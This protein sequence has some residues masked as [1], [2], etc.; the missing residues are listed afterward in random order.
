ML[1]AEGRSLPPI[2]GDRSVFQ[3]DFTGDDDPIH[4]FNWSHRRR[5]VLLF[6]C[7]MTTCSSTFSSAIFSQAIQ[8]VSLEYHVAPIVATLGVSLF[9]FGFST[10]PL[11]WGPMSEVFGRKIV[12]SMT[13]LLCAIFL[14]S[15]AASRSIQAIL[16]TRFFG[17]FFGGAPQA[18]VGGVMADIYRPQHR[19]IALGYFGFATFIGPLMAPIVGSY[20]VKNPHLNW[21]LLQIVAGAFQVLV[22][23]LLLFVM[24]ETYHPIVLKRKAFMLRQTTGNWAIHAPIDQHEIN[25]HS[26]LTK[27]VMRPIEMLLVEPILFLTSLYVSVTFGMLYMMLIA[28]PYIFQYQ[29]HF[30]L[31]QDTLP[32]ISM[33]IGLAVGCFFIGYLNFYVVDSMEKNNGKAV[34]EMRLP[35]MMIGGV[36]LPVGVFWMTWTAAYDVHWI[37]PTIAASFVGAGL[38]MV[39]LPGV[40]YIIDVYLIYAASASSINTIMRS[41]FA[42]SF[43]LFTKFMFD[44]LGIQWAGTLIGCVC[45]LLMPCPFLF[46]RYGAFLRS[47]SHWNPEEAMK[48]QAATHATK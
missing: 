20:I 3:V 11:F 19:G 47:K 42:A 28:V 43:P 41:G 8:P 38:I 9:V 27:T 7:S 26:L 35:P 30:P 21:R 18:I 22:L 39:F 31:G 17:G 10:G 33:F 48:K 23:L 34:P 6:I 25:L 16:L 2:P 13:A 46:Y 24:K 5:S 4:P 45:L 40:S 12:L 29:Y 44:D 37:C 1:L 14:F 15:T 36:A 32:Y